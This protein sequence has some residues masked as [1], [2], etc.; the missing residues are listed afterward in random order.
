MQLA[1]Q[2]HDGFPAELRSYVLD[3]P[4]QL[5][6]LQCYP[7]LPK[8][9][10]IRAVRKASKK[11]KKKAVKKVRSICC[12]ARCNAAFV[13]GVVHRFSQSSMPGAMP[14]ATV[15]AAPSGRMIS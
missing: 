1:P 8:L 5:L 14:R 10:W 12:Y 11:V 9:I 6:N 3:F 2:D 7:I 13:T 4:Y 15:K